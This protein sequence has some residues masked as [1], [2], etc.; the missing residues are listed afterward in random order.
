MNSP[1]SD[2]VLVEMERWEKGHIDVENMATRLKDAEKGYDNLK[3]KIKIL[4]KR[5]KVR[6]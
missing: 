6:F 3:D 1:S 5:V 4:E 2:S